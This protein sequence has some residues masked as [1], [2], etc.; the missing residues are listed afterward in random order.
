V[1]RNHPQFAHGKRYVRHLKNPAH[2]AEE[3]REDKNM[4]ATTTTGFS[5]PAYA[6]TVST[7][8]VR[9]NRRRRITPQAGSRAGTPR[10]CH[11]IPYRRVRASGLEVFLK[12][13]QLEAVQLLMALNR[14]VYFECPEVPTFGE[15]CRM[16]LHL[17]L[18]VDIHECS[19]DIAPQAVRR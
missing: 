7:V 11:R 8:R 13:E 6:P 17:R 3:E 16:L 4:A 9:A 14:Q 10:P 2:I 18:G 5:I 15:R 19:G 12:N 1:A